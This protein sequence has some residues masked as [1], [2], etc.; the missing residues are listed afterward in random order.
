MRSGDAQR[1]AASGN[2]DAGRTLALR[3]CTGCHVVSADQPFPPLLTA[4]QAPP[5]F[6]A[7]VNKPNTTE[8]SLHRFLSTLPPVPARSHM[9][10]PELSHR[11]L[12][13]IIAF[14]LT[15][16]ERR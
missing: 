13:D 12:E 2:A 16:Q 9:A 14:M 8:A 3:F 4:P 10:N 15:L 1:L 6:H 7:I 11:E 5:D